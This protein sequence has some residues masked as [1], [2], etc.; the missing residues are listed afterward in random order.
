MFVYLFKA[1]LLCKNDNYLENDIFINRLS[2]TRALTN[3][4]ILRL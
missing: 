2:T 1:F 3:I 4:L